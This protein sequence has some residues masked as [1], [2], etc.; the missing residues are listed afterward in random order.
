MPLSL[1]FGILGLAFIAAPP[2]GLAWQGR[3]ARRLRSL[4]PLAGFLVSMITGSVI[5]II[6]AIAYAVA[7]EGRVRA[8][9]ILITTYFAIGLLLVLRGLNWLLTQAID[10]PLRVAPGSPRHMRFRTARRTIAVLLRLGALYAIG[11]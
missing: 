3:R 5:G 4:R 10:R 1:P 7:L 11:L 6:I 9:Q 2:V 8:S